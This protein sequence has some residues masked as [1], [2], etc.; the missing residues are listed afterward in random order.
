MKRYF[1]AEST[2][3]LDIFDAH[4]NVWDGNMERRNKQVCV[5]SR[6]SSLDTTPLL[7]AR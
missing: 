5:E 4:Q 6:T 3:R 1:I 7:A 2:E